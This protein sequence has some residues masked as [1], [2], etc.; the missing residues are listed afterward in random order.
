MFPLHAQLPTNTIVPGIPVSTETG[1][2]SYYVKRPLKNWNMKKL[3]HPLLHI[4]LSTSIVCILIGIPSNSYSQFMSTQALY[5]NGYKSY[6][7]KDW[8]YASVYLYAYIQRTPLEFIDGKY[9]EEVIPAYNYCVTQLNNQSQEYKKL[10]PLEENFTKNGVASI[11]QRLVKCPPT[12]RDPSQIPADIQLKAM[13]DN[14]RTI[15]MPGI[16]RY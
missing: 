14:L 9:R 6:A 10:M 1:S 16:K 2:A 3:A 15:P 11:I 13:F 5:E 8:V 12:L 7:T 4:L